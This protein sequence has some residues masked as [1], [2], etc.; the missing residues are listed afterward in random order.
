MRVHF[1]LDQTDIG[2]VDARAG[3]RR[4]SEFIAEAVRRALDSEE[5]LGSI[6]SAIGSIPDT[7]HEWDHDVAEWVRR[8]RHVEIG[9]QRVAQ[10]SHEA[11]SQ[12]AEA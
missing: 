7:G 9:D 2:R 8:Q 11:S 3:A 12:L 1:T 10:T 5:P 6:E 4:R